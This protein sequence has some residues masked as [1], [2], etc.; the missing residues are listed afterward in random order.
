MTDQRAN[1]KRNL[2]TST[3]IAMVASISIAQQSPT[4]R[5][6]PEGPTVDLK[7]TGSARYDQSPTQPWNRIQHSIVLGLTLHANKQWQ[8]SVLGQTGPTYGRRYSTT[9]D[10]N[11]D[12]SLPFGSDIYL[13]QFFA[14]RTLGEKSAV[15]FGILGTNQKIAATTQLGLPYGIG[16]NGW[17]EGARVNTKAQKFDVSLTAG[18]IRD[19]DQPN[20]FVRSRRLNYIEMQI[21]GDLLR[22]L[23]F[24]SSAGRLDHNSF[25]R[26]ALHEKLSLAGKPILDLFGEALHDATADRT[27]YSM[28]VA[29]DALQWAGQSLKGF[30]EV[31]LQRSYN[32]KAN[33]WGLRGRLVNDWYPDGHT[34]TIA[35]RGKLNASGTWTWFIQRDWG[36]R[37]RQ[38]YGT[39][40]TFNKVDIPFKHH[41]N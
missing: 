6:E 8:V 18:S 17:I 31:E 4:P 5:T 38:Q 41:S 10:F 29:K 16:S 12:K 35:L 26:L 21:S 9:Y 23:A 1:F 33:Q 37:Q 2:W 40:Y 15:Q 11:A 36:T 24:E 27:S 20:P 34:N 28:K 32:P 25:V 14:Q 30:L 3:L 19:I 22:S 13:K 7:V 39:N